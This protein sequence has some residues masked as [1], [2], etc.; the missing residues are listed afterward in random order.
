[1]SKCRYA[2]AQAG[3]THS[4]REY[5]TVKH[6]D[7]DLFHVVGLRLRIRRWSATGSLRAIVVTHDREVPADLDRQRFR[8][9]SK[10]SCPGQAGQTIH[11]RRGW[12]WGWT[13]GAVVAGQNGGRLARLRL[14]RRLHLLIRRSTSADPSRR[15]TFPDNVS[16]SDSRQTRFI[17]PFSDCRVDYSQSDSIYLDLNGYNDGGGGSALEAYLSVQ[18]ECHLSRDTVHEIQGGSLLLPHI[19]TCFDCH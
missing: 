7:L 2:E 5:L 18:H 6:Q 3:S 19:R 17:Q 15:M 11:G 16:S 10:M 8:F 1:M 14:R 13:Q 9:A 12:T 4:T